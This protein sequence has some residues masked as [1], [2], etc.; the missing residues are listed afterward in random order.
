[1]AGAEVSL[2]CPVAIAPVTGDG[3]DDAAGYGRVAP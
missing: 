2:G 3:R 1:M